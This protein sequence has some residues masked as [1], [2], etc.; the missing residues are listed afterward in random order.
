MHNLLQTACFLKTA[1]L[2]IAL[3]V[4]NVRFLLPGLI[5]CHNLMSQVMCLSL[6]HVPTVLPL[7]HMLQRSISTLKLTNLLY[8][9]YVE[10]QR[11]SLFIVTQSAVKCIFLKP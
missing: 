10:V 1:A 9:L 3:R 7:Q 11:T 4:Y 6:S 5:P 8:E 2:K